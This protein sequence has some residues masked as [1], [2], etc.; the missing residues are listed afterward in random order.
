MFLPGKFHPFNLNS[1]V[2]ET[3]FWELGSCI[4]VRPWSVPHIILITTTCP[5]SICVKLGSWILKA[6]SKRVKHHRFV[7]GDGMKSADILSWNSRQDPIYNS[8]G[9]IQNWVHSKKY[10]DVD[11]LESAYRACSCACCLLCPY[12]LHSAYDVSVSFLTLLMLCVCI[13]LPVVT[14]QSDICVCTL[15]LLHRSSCQS[16]CLCVICLIT[17]CCEA[18]ST[19]DKWIF[20]VLS[21]YK[22]IYSIN[23]SLKE[24]VW[25]FKK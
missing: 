7:G 21:F 16:V 18:L 8:M 10:C 22:H 24:T 25:H 17:P 13:V 3:S 19:Y 9:G 1:F 14:S 12:F 23:M 15:C 4:Q 6:N 11:S 2:L 5:Q 20:Y